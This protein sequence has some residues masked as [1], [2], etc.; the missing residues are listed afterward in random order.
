MKI[1]HLTSGV[2]VS[3]LLWALQANPHLWNQHQARTQDPASPHH[4]VHD[5]WVRY[6]ALA[7]AGKPGPHESVWYPESQPIQQ[8][9]RAIVYPLMHL[10]QANRLGGILITKIPAGKMCKPHRDD[11]WHARYYRKFAVQVQSAPGQLFHVEEQ[12]LEPAPGDVYEFQN[13]FEHWVT[14]DTPHDRV[15]M[16]VCL[17]TDIEYAPAVG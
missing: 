10:V 15:T 3:R 8:A 16:I 12:S 11:G 9:V 14:N 5:I 4:E 7:E 1:R 6:A 2:E 13:H 17:Q